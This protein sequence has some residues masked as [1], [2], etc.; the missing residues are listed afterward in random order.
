MYK[1]NA[2]NTYEKV[3]F[4]VSFEDLQNLHSYL[5]L[6]FKKEFEN[7]VSLN[8]SFEKIKNIAKHYNQLF[9]NIDIKNLDYFVN[10]QN[11]LVLKNYKESIIY[12][13]SKI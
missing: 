5:F 9:D 12:T 10:C 8:I 11:P 7:E 4:I 2:L 3:K 13:I 6:I 1:I